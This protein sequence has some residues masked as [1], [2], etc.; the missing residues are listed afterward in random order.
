M[1]FNTRVVTLDSV[2]GDLEDSDLQ[3]DFLK[4]DAEG[5]QL[6]HLSMHTCLHTCLHACVWLQL[7]LPM[8]KVNVL[9]VAGAESLIVSGGQRLLSTH[10]PDMLVEAFWS[11]R[12]FK[13]GHLKALRDLIALGYRGAPV[14]QGEGDYFLT[15]RGKPEIVVESTLINGSMFVGEEHYIIWVCAGWDASLQPPIQLS[16][17]GLSPDGVD[18]PVAEP[19]VLQP[20]EA[21]SHDGVDVVQLGGGSFRF[22]GDSDSLEPGTYKLQL[23]CFSED[24]SAPGSDALRTELTVIA[25]KK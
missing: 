15:R 14:H 25:R 13:L 16:M 9:L 11:D 4:I 18:V 2:I 8:R 22:P 24:D 3:A 21:R 23:E 12:Y 6:Q 20:H 17:S 19:V 10:W 5:T 1:L 7:P